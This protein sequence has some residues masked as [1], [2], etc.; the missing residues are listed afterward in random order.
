MREL[1]RHMRNGLGGVAV[2]FSLL[3]LMA[4]GLTLSPSLDHSAFAQSVRPPANAVTPAEMGQNPRNLDVSRYKGT[5]GEVRRGMEGFVGIPDQKEGVL[6]QAS[7]QVWRSVHTGALLRWGGWGLAIVVVLIGIFYVWR[8][9]IAIEHGKSGHLV[10]RFNAIE[11]F[12]HWLLASTFIVL[13]ITGLNMLFGRRLFLSRPGDINV[14]PD[15]SSA[16]GFY[17]SLTYWGKIVHDFS[18]W[19]FI[20]GLILVFVLWVGQNIPNKADLE[21]LAK[22]GGLFSKGVHPPSR[23]FNAGQ[24]VIFWL[25]VILGGTLAFSGLCLLFPFQISPWSGT[26][27]FLNHFGFGLPT[28]LL[29]IQE[30]QLSQLW[31]AIVALVLIAVIIGHIYIG[32][33]GMEGA[34]DAMGTGKVDENWAREHHSVW[35]DEMAE[36]NKDAA[37]KGGHAQPAE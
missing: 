25:V 3:Y 16:Q 24:K 11:R 20:A 9:T 10:E 4:A 31:H 13:A 34:F 26:F 1:A 36:A 8:G 14:A 7:G 37:A 18:S 28:K 2:A 21:W 5:W 35:V 27:A 32:T 22:G 6:V 19:G 17:A 15:F 23:K 29:A 30:M 33:L 12:A